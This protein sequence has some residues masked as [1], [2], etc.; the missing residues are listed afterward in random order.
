MVKNYLME[1]VAFLDADSVADLRFAL[2]FL[3]TRV[4]NNLRRREF[5]APSFDSSVVLAL[6]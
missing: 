1:N 2:K 6:L 3:H 5:V 4:S